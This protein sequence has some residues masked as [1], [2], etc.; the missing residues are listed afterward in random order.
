MAGLHNI[1]LKMTVLAEEVEKTVESKAEILGIY[2]YRTKDKTHYYQ[3]QY[4]EVN[5]QYQVD[6]ISQSLHR[7]RDKSF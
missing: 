2:T 3:F 1:P 7:N 5:K 4:L 6:I